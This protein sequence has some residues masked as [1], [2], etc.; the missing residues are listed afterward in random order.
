MRKV[1]VF[2]LEDSVEC[3]KYEALL[4][5]PTVIII[6]E[7]FAYIKMS[8]APKLTVWYDKEG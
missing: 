8:G 3:A 6:K 7:E 2:E 1:E 4:N 5:D